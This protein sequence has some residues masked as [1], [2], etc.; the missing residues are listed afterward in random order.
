M[1]RDAT[2]SVIVSSR[3]DGVPIPSATLRELT[4]TDQVESRGTY[5]VVAYI[6]NSNYTV[7]QPAWVSVF[8]KGNVFYFR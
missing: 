5:D 3:K 6:D 2:R 8:H 7:S 4:I 1:P